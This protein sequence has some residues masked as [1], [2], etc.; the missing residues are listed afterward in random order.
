MQTAKQV[1]GQAGEEAALA[2][3]L[4]HGLTL[5]T[6]NF[7]CKAGEIDLIMREHASLVFVEVRKRASLDYGGAAASITPAKQRR[8]LRAAQ[9]YLL[10]F[11]TLPAC[12]FDVVAIDAGHLSWLKN[13]IAA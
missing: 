4:Q 11:K 7:R 13:A 6:R 12:R 3:L 10:R 5:V 1:Q 2:Y 9:V 8:L